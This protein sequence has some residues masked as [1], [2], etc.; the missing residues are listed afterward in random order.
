MKAIEILA[1]SRKINE[2]PA[3]VVGQ[4]LKRLGAGVLG[5]MGAKGMAGQLAG[6]A[7]Q[8]AKANELFGNFKR[9]LGQIGKDKNTAVVQDLED[10]LVKNKMSTKFMKSMNIKSWKDIDKFFTAMAQ[11]SFKGGSVKSS[12]AP[13]DASEPV[14]PTFKPA[15]RQVRDNPNAGKPTAAAATSATQVRAA[16]DSLITSIGSVRSRDR[17]RIIDYVKQ[18]LDG[19][20]PTPNIA[21]SNAMGQMANQLGGTSGTTSTG[22]TATVTPTGI[23]N[24]ASPT[25]PNKVAAT[26]KRKPKVAAAV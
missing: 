7:D 3:N 10:F 21:P 12:A 14:E 1:E 15:G 13:A 22:G 24:K 8:G 26:P 19:L 18:K 20:S 4:G 23:K 9:Y 6:D 25:N 11:D 2:A 5:A 17:Q 16:A